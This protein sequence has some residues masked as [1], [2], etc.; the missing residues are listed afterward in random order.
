MV[1]GKVWTTIWKIDGSMK[2]MIVRYLYYKFYRFILRTPNRDNAPEGGVQL[3]V[4][5]LIVNFVSSFYWIREFTGE[6]NFVVLSFLFLGLCVAVYF[7]GYRYF[8]KLE[9]YKEVVKEFGTEPQS[10]KI[11]GVF[12]VIFLFVFLYLAGLTSQFM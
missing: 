9:K 11:M 6:I 2:V 8:V 7:F 4:L 3:L 1:L 12:L 10:K 5:L